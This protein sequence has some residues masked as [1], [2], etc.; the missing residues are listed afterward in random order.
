MVDSVR[1][2]VLG[3]A[4]RCRVELECAGHRERVPE[5]VKGGI[6]RT[7]KGVLQRPWRDVRCRGDTEK[8]DIAYVRGLETWTVARYDGRAHPCSALGVNFNLGCWGK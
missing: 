7:E 8:F 5:G 1:I 2:R 6:F 4:S 3:K